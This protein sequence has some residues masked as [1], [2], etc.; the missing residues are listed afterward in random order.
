MKSQKTTPVIVGIC[1]YL[2]S[3]GTT[4]PLDPLSL[5]VKT[6][7]GAIAD[8]EAEEIKDFIDAIYMVNINSWSYN[9]APGQLSEIIG[10]KPKVKVF[11]PDGGDT[12]QMLTNRAAKAITSG[13]LNA[14]LITGGEAQY[15]SNKAKKENI[16]LDW[17]EFT[18]PSY[19]EGPL[20]DG[21]NKWENLYGFKIPPY[22][23]ALLETSVR[24]SSGR[25][26]EEHR[27]HM[28]KLFE[29]FAE[30]AS[31]H[32]N[33]WSK[34]PYSAEEIT[35]PS[36]EN[37]Y[38]N[39]PYTKRMC[40]NMFV[41]QSASLIIT[42]EA[43]ANKLGIKRDKWVY[44]M[45][46]ADSKDV[47]DITRKPRLDNSPAMK[48]AASRALGQAGLELAEINKF[49]FYSCFPSIVEIMMKE[50][51]LDFSDERDL[52]LTGGL[53]FF[54][55]PWS[56]YSMHAIITAID[57][58]RKD[59][60]LKIMVV[61]NGGYNSKKSVGIYG[62]SPPS[63]SWDERDDSKLQKKILD[64]ILPEPIKE[65]EGIMTIEA[66]TIPYDR[67][68]KPKYGIVIGQLE[69]GIRTIASLTEEQDILLKFETKELIGKQC[70]VEFDPNSGR[71]IA[72]LL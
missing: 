34:E 40:A 52:T 57:H 5:I 47:H 13:N 16:K 41:D 49:D 12:P 35:T 30:V 70:E 42:S 21:I 60:S 71:N 55:G 24:A 1:Q 28:G 64:N 51:E 56:N 39:H 8:T 44:L 43:I 59:S 26:L 67:S 69:N 14:V 65:A 58:I 17:P 19:M 50:L 27:R 68:G 53:P 66:Y 23:Y 32:P 63:I 45:G 38:I 46:C 15:S 4:N 36:E 31:K 62:T 10:V 48:A 18:E 33:S 22:L 11:L 54:G 25:S 37:R 20:W 72:K 29:H 7:Q 61:A 6:S 2:Q 9:D 3:K